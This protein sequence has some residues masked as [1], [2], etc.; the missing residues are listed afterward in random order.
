MIRDAGDRIEVS[1][2]LTLGKAREMLEAGSALIK[3]PETVFDLSQVKE[4]DSSGLT[5]VFGWV[6]AAKSQGKSA[7]IS[8]P[9][10]NLL[11]LAAL[12]GVTELLPLA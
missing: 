2:P 4:V 3:R 1:G 10:Q 11:S 8:N 7:R 12:Y 6:R 9:P 5:V